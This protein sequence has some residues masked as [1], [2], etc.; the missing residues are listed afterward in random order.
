[1]SKMHKTSTPPKRAAVRAIWIA[2]D[3]DLIEHVR[4]A[5]TY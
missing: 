1:M 4:E 3:L 5:D 2:V